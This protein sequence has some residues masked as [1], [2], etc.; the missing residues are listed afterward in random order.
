MGLGLE[1]FKRKMYELN[2]NGFFLPI[3]QQFMQITV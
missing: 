3:N 1:R 2:E